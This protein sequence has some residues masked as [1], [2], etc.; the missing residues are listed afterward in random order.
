MPNF[1]YT[2]R[3][4]SGSPLNGTLMAD[5]LDAAVSMLRGEGKYPT[6]VTPAN[7][8]AARQTRVIL[9]GRL[10]RKELIH[11]CQQLQIMLETGVTLSDALDCLTR[12]KS[13]PHV[14]R[15]MED[16][17]TQVQGGATFST[18]LA[19]H[20]RSFPRLLISLMAA[21][22]KSGLMSKLLTR[23][24]GYLR[25]EQDA[26]RRVR[27]ALTYPA[28]MMCFAI[29]TT[30]FLLTFVLPKFTAIFASKGAALPV[31]TRILMAVS[32]FLIGNWI[33]LVTGI[34]AFII[35]F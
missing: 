31:P 25:D 11:F 26:V 4:S 9:G 22:E 5:T 18:A 3:D 15:I 23:A 8:P 21:S 17:R 12:H 20:P 32:G 29:T 34:L 24:V 2:A 10:S 33:Y 16:I 19:R 14:Q 30:T 7:A 35:A 13:K 28:I 1:A 6:S 27:G